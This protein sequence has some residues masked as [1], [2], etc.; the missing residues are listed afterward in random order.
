MENFAY[1]LPVRIRCG[2]GMV[3][4]AGSEAVQHG[5]SAVIIAAA[6]SQDAAA[7]AQASLSEAGVKSPI[8]IVEGNQATAAEA[9]KAAKAGRDAMATLVIAV[10]DNTVCDIARLTAYGLFD[11]DKVWDQLPRLGE[12]KDPE[13][14][15]PLVL[16]PTQI[17]CSVAHL[18]SGAVTNGATNERVAFGAD[19][20]QPKALLLDPE[21]TYTAPKATTNET[22]CLLIGSLLDGYLFGND[23][24]TPVQDRLVEAL[25][26]TIFENL[27]VVASNPSNYSA[28]ANLLWVGAMAST[29][30]C[31]TG[32][33]GGKPI[34]ALANVLAGKYNMA[35][36]RAT[37]LMTGALMLATCQDNCERIAR[38]G[39]RLFGLPIMS[40]SMEEAAHKGVLQLKKWFHQQGCLFTLPSAGVPREEIDGLEP[41]F[42][43]AVDGVLSA[44]TVNAV[45]QFASQ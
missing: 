44:D 15:A 37:A 17:L 29:G 7:K 21:I 28:R 35:P 11:P 2:R 42:A 4:Q 6:D 31:D 38:L 8:H 1:Q 23:P 12:G 10:G 24:N 40:P 16:I 39:H 43:K 36:G 27:P 41:L 32:R 20:L 33:G 26:E 18:G 19:N 25:I 3:A 30:L 14:A 9:A 45:V 13:R 22:A 34:A 5:K